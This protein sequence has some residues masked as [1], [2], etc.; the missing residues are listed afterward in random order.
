MS[1]L[2]TP[3]VRPSRMVVQL[4]HEQVINL[5]MYSEVLQV[6]LDQTNN[7]HRHKQKIFDEILRLNH[8]L[9]EFEL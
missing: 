6:T 8:F 9:K 4:T 5:S 1:T 3:F 7:N 2:L